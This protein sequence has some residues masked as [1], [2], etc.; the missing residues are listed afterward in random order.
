MRD[1]KLIYFYDAK[2]DLEQGKWKAAAAQASIARVS[3]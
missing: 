3:V 2:D 1:E